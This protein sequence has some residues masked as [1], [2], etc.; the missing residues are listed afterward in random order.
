MEPKPLVFVI[1]DD[2]ETLA[3]MRD[4]LED[5]GYAVQ[6]AP[7]ARAALATLEKNAVPAIILVDLLTPG[8]TAYEFVR[9]IES[10]SRLSAVPTVIM[11][12][13][14]P[15]PEDA[16]VAVPILR[17]PISLDALLQTLA[18]YCAPPWE[19]AEAPTDRSS[20]L[21]ND[22]RPVTETRQPDSTTK[23][24]CMRCAKRAVGRCPGCG[25]A[26]CADCLQTGSHAACWAAA[27]ER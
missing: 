20:I 7:N 4:L 14:R 15:S 16:D 9:A 13:A 26:F 10:S 2:E 17:K 23:Q 8:M 11:S 19:E 18:D 1:D 24:A 22:G 12:G 25:E 21:V 6:T 27:R 5:E 3:T